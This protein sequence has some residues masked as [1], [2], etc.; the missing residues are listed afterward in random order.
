M[1]GSFFWLFAD[2][3]DEVRV[4]KRR[5]AEVGPILYKLCE[6]FFNGRECVSEQPMPPI[7]WSVA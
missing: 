7:R 6:S 2:L 5:Q 3:R 4:S 1:R